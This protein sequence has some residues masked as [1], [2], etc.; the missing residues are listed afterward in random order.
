MNTVVKRPNSER[1]R[2]AIFALEDC[3]KEMPQ[4]E[5]EWIHRFTPGLYTREMIVPAG[6]ILTGY[7]HKTEHISI[8]LE[9][10]ML[11]PDEN[12]G[13]KEIVAPIVEIAQPGI[14]RVGLALEDVR[15]I[16]VHPTN[17]TDVEAIEAEIVTND[18]SEVEHL[19]EN[20]SEPDVRYERGHCSRDSTSGVIIGPEQTEGET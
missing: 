18:Y 14:K 9:G 3:I 4:A 11:V 8:F 12:G 10:R 17:L 20:L 2:N 13:S 1:M 16:T 6:V 7:I 15:W 19:L 5:L